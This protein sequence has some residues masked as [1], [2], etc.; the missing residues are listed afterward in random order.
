[1]KTVLILAAGVWLGRRIYTT[2]ADNKARERD[3]E[4]RKRLDRFM[5][6]TIPAMTPEEVQ[7]QIST[8]LK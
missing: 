1:M 2:L 4:L 5:R 6:D 8:L 7:Q 3:V